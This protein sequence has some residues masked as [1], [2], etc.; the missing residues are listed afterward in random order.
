MSRMVLMV[1]GLSFVVSGEQ[2]GAM[3]ECDLRMR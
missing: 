1:S 3:K 2:P